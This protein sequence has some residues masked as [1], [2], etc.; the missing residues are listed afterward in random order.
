MEL[1]RHVCASLDASFWI[2]GGRIVSW[3]NRGFLG[4][5]ISDSESAVVLIGGCQS[6]K[7]GSMPGPQSLVVSPGYAHLYEWEIK[8]AK[9]HGGE[10]T[11]A[12]AEAAAS[13]AA[14]A[15][16]CRA[17]IGAFRVALGRVSSDSSSEDGAVLGTMP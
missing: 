17:S 7:I 8:V 9:T 2:E 13:A 3:I 1:A 11:G 10:V 6:K 5:E 12:A 14:F 16:P 15:S 4:R